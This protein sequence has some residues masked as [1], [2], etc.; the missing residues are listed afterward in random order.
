[1]RNGFIIERAIIHQIK[2]VNSLILLSFDPV[3]WLTSVAS[4]K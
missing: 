3:T 2:Y 4:W 1:M